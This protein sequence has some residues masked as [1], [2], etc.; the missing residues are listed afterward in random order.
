MYF[1][2]FD[3]DYCYSL[4]RVVSLFISSGKTG[5][6]SSDRNLTKP[7]SEWVV[8][9]IP[10]TAMMNMEK[11]SGKVKPVIQKAIF[12]LDVNR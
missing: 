12:K 11:R 4:G 6:M 2:N 10:I 8:R 7:D 5:Y 9:G 1:L 3:A